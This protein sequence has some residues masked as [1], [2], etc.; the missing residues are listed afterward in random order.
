M[1]PVKIEKEMMDLLRLDS[2]GYALPDYENF[3]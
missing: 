1:P 3:I 2:P